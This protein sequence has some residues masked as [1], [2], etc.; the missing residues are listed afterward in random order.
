[1]VCR[2]TVARER[3]NGFVKR[4]IELERAQGGHGFRAGRD[5]QMSCARALNLE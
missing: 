2:K 5:R 3:E 1:M 4:R